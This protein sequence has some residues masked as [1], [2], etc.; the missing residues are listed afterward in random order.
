MHNINL[1]TLG[2]MFGLIY[3]D[4]T[5]NYIQNNGQR[6]GKDNNN[7]TQSPTRSPTEHPT[8]QFSDSETPSSQENM[9]I[10]HIVTSV[11]L[12]VGLSL[13]LG[14]ACGVLACHVYHNKHTNALPELNPM[15]LHPRWSGIDTTHQGPL[16]QDTDGLIGDSLTH[17]EAQGF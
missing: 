6:T 8:F 2:S 5:P 16:F 13:C 14:F 17:S 3:A 7:I 10:I 15:A 9:E 4:A 12:Y 11:L 1:L